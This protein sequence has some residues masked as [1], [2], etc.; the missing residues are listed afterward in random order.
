MNNIGQRIRELRKKNDL[1]QNALADLL[2]VTDKAVSKW[3]CGLTIPDIAMIGPLTK[4]LHT[5]AD[6]LLGLNVEEKDKE[7]K[8]Y[9]QAL[10]KFYNCEAPQLN[11]AW[12]RAATIDFPNDYRYTEW[13]ASAEYQLAFKEY[14]RSDNNRSA[15]FISEMTDNALRRY[16]TV[17]DNCDEQ[18]LRRKAAIGKIITLRFCERIDEAEWSA[19]FE[20]PDRNINNACDIMK[21]THIGQ[22]L[23]ALLEKE[24]EE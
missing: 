11:Y 7:R 5:S 12:A 16:E 9:D 18:E 14:Q 1:T 3:E 22:E 6:E 21:M 2:A 20:Y 8:K 13:L 19:K 24:A 10:Q 4:I 23:L 15:E 17:I